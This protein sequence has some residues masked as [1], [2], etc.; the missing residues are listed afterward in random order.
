ML[1]LS[2]SAVT[3]VVG[4]GMD[5]LT[6]LWLDVGGGEVMGRVGRVGRVVRLWARHVKE[7][8][9]LVGRVRLLLIAGVAGGSLLLLLAGLHVALQVELA[10][11]RAGRLAPCPSHS[12][13]PH[14]IPRYAGLI[15]RANT[16]SRPLPPNTQAAVFSSTQI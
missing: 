5:R 11:H 6:R 13:C 3:E 2:Q 10:P 12:H 1:K 8:I 14:R 4:G 9:E 7:W 16:S 15:S